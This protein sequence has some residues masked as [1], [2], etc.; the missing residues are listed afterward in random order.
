MSTYHDDWVLGREWLM[1]KCPGVTDARYNSMAA[2][3]T[4]AILKEGR[5]ERGKRG[6]WLNRR[7]LI[8]DIYG[9]APDIASHAFFQW[10]PG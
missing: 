4:E 3:D 1:A 5:S 7:Y 10:L 8:T 6:I 9:V 2:G